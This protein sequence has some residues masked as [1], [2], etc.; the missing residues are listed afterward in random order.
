MSQ[1]PP[2]PSHPEP[3]ENSVPSEPSEPQPIA[4]DAIAPEISPEETAPITPD[5]ITSQP[6]PEETAP[7]AAVPPATAQT[8]APIVEDETIP[9]TVLRLLKRLL[10]QG[11]RLLI[12]LLEAIVARL[13]ASPATTPPAP[14]QVEGQTEPGA[15]APAVPAE[16]Q[17]Q[18]RWRQTQ[19][20]WSELLTEVRSLLPESVNQRVSNPV[21]TGTIGVVL[22]AIVWTASTLLFGEPPKPT[23]VATVP[24]PAPTEVPTP[25][26]TIVPPEL[27][28]P[29]PQAPV[30]EKPIEPV[31]P[32]L[33]KPSPAPSPPLQLTPEQKLIAS[34]QEQVAQISDRYTGGLIQSVQANFRGSRLTVKLG[35]DWYRLTS[36]Q[37][38]KL[39]N[40]MLRRAQE[41]DFSKLELVD[42]SETLLARSPVV[43]TEMVILR[44]STELQETV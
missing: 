40:E 36:V 42:P 1:E 15:T 7:I 33:V 4:P 2:E 14:L 22:V 6:A 17:V 12:Q 11:L 43:G 3:P 27:E 20:W 26:P 29:E 32:P 18:E 28:A 38:D 8:T 16:N 39:A 25:P 21:L 44:R 41:L 19:V 35:E 5:A 31:P 9:Q 37:Q 24:S 13:E 30:A 10:I 34:I 23:D